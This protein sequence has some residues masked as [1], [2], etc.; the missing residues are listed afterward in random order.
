VKTVFL[1]DAVR[2]NLILKLQKFD[3]GN[4]IRRKTP[5]IC[6]QHFHVFPISKIICRGLIHCTEKRVS[7]YAKSDSVNNLP[8]EESIYWI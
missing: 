6:R 8:V 2:R 4:G 7:F 3:E 1:C 5:K